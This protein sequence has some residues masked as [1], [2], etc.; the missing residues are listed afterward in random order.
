MQRQKDESAR[1]ASRDLAALLGQWRDE[2]AERL[3]RLQTQDLATLQ[4]QQTALEKNLKN[5]ALPLQKLMGGAIS[6]AREAGEDLKQS[7]EEDIR[8]FSKLSARQGSRTYTKS[9]EVSTS[10]WY[11][12][13]T[14]GSTKTVY[15]TYT[16]SYSFLSPADAVENVTRYE[17][18]CARS[19]EQAF[20]GLLHPATLIS[21]LRKAL[22]DELAQRQDFDPAAFRHVMEQAL[23]QLNLPTLH[24]PTGRASQAIASRFS[25][26]ITSSGEQSQLQ[27]ALNDALQSVFETLL[28][29]FESSSH[30]LFERLQAVQNSLQA[31][32]S[33]S[34]K[35]DLEQARHD[36]ANQQQQA[37][38]Y[39]AL[40]A[41]LQPLIAHPEKALAQG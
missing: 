18:E 19:I 4:A 16:E 39:E 34:L 32:L 26:E 5:I 21:Q 35:A 28:G 15:R 40:L 24:L 36:F 38:R 1:D 22:A 23:S 14:W 25:G 33:A 31:T 27:N 8:R 3:K 29:E 2:A 30:K 37:R 11:K 12:P 41:A 7:L 9:R 6:K 17:R 20:G 13:W 10:K